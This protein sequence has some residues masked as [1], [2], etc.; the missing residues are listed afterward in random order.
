[1][2][3]RLLVLYGLLAA[4]FVLA[5]ATK[6]LVRPPQENSLQSVPK[7]GLDSGARS[8][9]EQSPYMRTER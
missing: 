6:A 9:S 3:A 1:M 4:F 2:N 7:A 8:V 5:A